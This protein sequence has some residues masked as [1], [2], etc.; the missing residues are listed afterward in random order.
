MTTLSIVVVTWNG[1]DAIGATLRAVASELEPGDELIVCDNASADDTVASAR[2]A[3]P[4]A[5]VIET[6]A[7][8][9]FPAACNLG[10][11]RA[12]GDLLCFLNPDAV[13][14]PG[15][16]AAIVAP[17]AEPDG[18]GAWQALVTSEGGGVVNTRGGV[19]HFTGIAWAGGAGEPVP[20]STR[21]IAAS[22]PGFVSGAALAIGRDLFAELGGFAAGFF[23]YHE[24]VD[25][26]LR[27]RL[28]GRRLAVAPDA[29]VDHDYDFDKGL[30]KWRH[31]ERNRWATIVRTYPGA[32]LALLAPALL[33]TELALL[34]VA[35]AGGWL[36]QKLGAAGDLARSLPRLLRE[37]RTIA[38][39]RR[40]S[41]SEFASGLTPGLDS[42]YLGA[43][44][45]LPLLGGGLRVYWR[46]VRA[47]LALRR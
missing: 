35:A 37:R 28:A 23:L 31:L 18:P 9:G 21:E 39:T 41:A 13:V 33:A 1:A 12:R 3:A 6:G 2:E 5:S 8:L 27:V 4:E 45:R 26:S 16:R 10:A 40:V 32:L 34:A 19:V 42:P 47:V 46:V 29:R 24:D 7:N 38:A 15:F 22:E 44:A 25:L 17:A 14:Q 36:P 20:G 43:A 11:E 30:A